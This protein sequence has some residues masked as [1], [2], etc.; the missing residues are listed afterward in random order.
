M[1]AYVLVQV[2]VTDPSKYDEYK[3]H[4]PAAIDKYGGRYLAR[5]GAT[6]NLE[7]DNTYGRIVLLEFPSMERAREWY[8]SPEYQAAKA[9]REGGGDGMFTL[10]EGLQ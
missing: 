1:S 5:G 10:I 3:K 9:Y 4:A 2:N 8:H 7:G 6:E